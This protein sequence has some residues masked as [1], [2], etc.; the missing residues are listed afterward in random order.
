MSKSDE[1]LRALLPELEC[2]VDAKCNAGR[3]EKNG[4]LVIWPGD[5]LRYGYQGRNQSDA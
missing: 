5:R 4:W 1:P 2:L 3:F